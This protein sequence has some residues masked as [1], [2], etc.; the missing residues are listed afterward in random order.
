YLSECIV[1]AEREK[2]VKVRKQLEKEC[3][4]LILRLWKER[5]Y[6]PEDARPLANLGE[7]VTVLAALQERQTDIE[8]WRSYIIDRNESGWG[9]FMK[10]TNKKFS[11]I[12]ALS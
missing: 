7:A 9:K 2:R 8:P 11:E 10:E 6:F 5:N 4:E 3:V 1:K 12:L